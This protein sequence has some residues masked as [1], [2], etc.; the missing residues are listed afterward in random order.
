[1]PHSGDQ[2]DT[3]GPTG[4]AG[5]LR[6][7]SRLNRSH[8]ASPAVTVPTTSARRSGP[9]YFGGPPN[10]DQLF[11]QLKAGSPLP[12]RVA[13]AA[14]FRTIV[15]EYALSSVTE[16]W[17][18]AQDMLDP[19]NSPDVRQ[20]ALKLMTACI[21][22]SDP[23]ALDRLHFYKIIATHPCLADFDDQL[24]AL[25][26]L[27]NNGKNVTSFE[28]DILG[29][30]SKWIRLWFKEAGQ[31]RQARKR[32]N[33]PSAALS[34][35]E[36]NFTQLM[37]FV[38]DIVKFNHSAFEER[39][40]NTL[41]SEFLSV[42]KKTTSRDDIKYSLTFIDVL[43]TYGYIPRQTLAQCIEVLCGAYTTVKELADT[44]WGAVAN[45]CRSYM[46]HNT[47]L[48]LRE[49]LGSPGRKSSRTNN[50]LRGAV[51]LLERLLIANEA[52]GLPA[53]QFSAVMVSF[54][55]ALAA[56]N[57]RLDMDIVKAISSIFQN[58]EIMKHVTVDEWATPL[59][60]LAQC[61]KRTTERADGTKLEVS[62]SLTSTTAYRPTSVHSKDRDNIGSAISA[63]LLQ[64]IIFLEGR[65]IL[66]KDSTLTEIVM[67]F[68]IHVH[69][70]LPD[71][72]ADLLIDYYAAEH[73]CYPSCIDWMTNMQ[74]LLAMFFKSKLRPARLR[75][76]VLTLV[77]D[78][79]ETIKGICDED[80]LQ[81]MILSVFEGIREEIDG[82]VLDALVRI[83]VDVSGGGN[84]VLFDKIIDILVDFI[85][86]EGKSTDQAQLVD[87]ACD[88]AHHSP[89]VVSS[90]YNFGSRLNTITTGL[91]R[92]F[93]RN[94]H[95][96]ARKA[97]RV[98]IEIVKV[99]G[100]AIA[101]VDARLTAMRLLFRIRSDAEHAILLV[102]STESES[103]AAFLGRLIK[104][105]EEKEILA[106][107][108]DEDVLSTSRLN[109]SCS[110]SLP[111]RTPSRSMA[112]KPKSKQRE[113]LWSY[114][115]TQLL[116]E[117]FTE[118]SSP[119]LCTY[120]DPPSVEQ[121]NGESPP[122]KFLS[123]ETCV[124]MSL[125]M[126]QVVIPIIQ[127][128]TNWEIYSY[129][130][131]NLASQISNKTTF[132]NCTP[133]IKYLRAYIC[134]QLH[135]N[136]IPNTD[137]PSEL[138]KA[139]IAVVLIHILTTLTCYHEHFAR[140]EQEAVVKAFQLGLHSWQRTARPCIH[141]LS[142][143]CYELP[144]PTSKFL[145]GILTKLSQIITSSAVSVHILEFLS[146][147][148][149]LPSLYA[150]FTEPDF[151]NVFG[152]AFRYIQHTKETT[153]Q[154][155]QRIN[156]P[157]RGSKD[158]PDSIHSEQP[159]LPQYV[160]TLAY[161]VLT[162][163]FLSLRLS[164]RHKYVSWITRGLVLGDNINGKNYIDEQSQAC[165][166]MLQ[167]FTYSDVGTQQ[168]PVH[169][170]F[171]NSSHIQTRN[172][173][174]G[175]SI[176]SIKMDTVTGDSEVTIRKPVSVY[177]LF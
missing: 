55:A 32:E 9:E 141:A 175:L 39:Q 164:E 36:S 119:V 111:S 138:R 85:P 140:N 19:Q 29:L 68:F 170:K 127:T 153:A 79:Y 52:D 157:G 62:N 134:D 172:W 152:I 144:M 107:C 45:L 168:S 132:R 10:N 121:L 23:T 21:K 20:A 81:E 93:I 163:W 103:M 117:P 87:V 69:G 106:P 24:L 73:L 120:K 15:A 1:M 59:D 146:A 162:T 34:A 44:T 108:K 96:S 12:D 27:T 94:M 113:L 77:K 50:S 47:V 155:A 18:A 136:K 25:V 158:S 166:D 124:R 63:S 104:P 125:W 167:Q 83:A 51:Y 169:T 22:H 105:A 28:K 130:L 118:E 54:R 58:E 46:A 135:T 133:H 145:S 74:R 17:L 49:I 177:S 154:Q 31:A 98:F 26:A 38:T 147:L 56:N 109:R 66:Q 156:H 176:I 80:Q 14:Q 139:D 70:H 143:C 159:T 126:E 99:A 114:P 90:T 122:E 42:C 137:L 92:I 123:K 72:A 3:R 40:V 60:I 57:A 142:V 129:V 86:T 95:T 161:N 100:C 13:A 33:G 61:S 7:L 116:P 65:C 115:E 101:D 89:L 148:A 160:L 64:I 151:R 8:P 97:A 71:S 5:V 75:I 131:V 149:R 102:R 41:L 76:S 88:E 6:N 84:R 48:V 171:Q 11:T 4:I 82:M 110:V 30:L 2:Q 150:N 37:R 16:I 91:V 174:N 112:E 53:I 173:L 165:I 78:V 35:V 128:G 43:I 67:E